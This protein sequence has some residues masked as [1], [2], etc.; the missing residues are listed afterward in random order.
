MLILPESRAA[1]RDELVEAGRPLTHPCRILVQYTTARS[2]DPDLAVA[3]TNCAV[4]R[5]LQLLYEHDLVGQAEADLLQ[6]LQQELTMTRAARDILQKDIN[7][8][9]A[10]TPPPPPPPPSS[11]PADENA[12]PAAPAPLTLTGQLAEWDT[13]IIDLRRQLDTARKAAKVCVS[14]ATTTC[15]RT[16]TMAPNP[17]MARDNKRCIGYD[18][19]E[20]FEGAFCGYWQSDVYSLLNSFTNMHTHSERH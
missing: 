19:M 14:S 18:T 10:H 8:L 7:G 17:W 1:L 16:S 12:P 6:Q 4:G 9:S 13:K 11:P 20:G 3:S 5:E 15:G 2:Q